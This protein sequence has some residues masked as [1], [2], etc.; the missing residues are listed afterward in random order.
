MN[1]SDKLEALAMCLCAQIT[2]DGSPEP[3][4]CGVVPGDGVS[5][6]YGTDCDARDGMAWVRINAMYPSSA[7]GSQDTTV[8]NCGSE[9]GVDIELGIMRAMPIDPNGEQIDDADLLAV[10]RQQTK[11]ALT[12]F[13]AATCCAAIPGKELIVG[14]YTPAGPLGGLVGGALLINTVA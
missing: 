8:N 2:A 3:C 11:D 7:V 12:L 6:T 4:F 5:L 9:I 10:T 1:L 13:R 14:A